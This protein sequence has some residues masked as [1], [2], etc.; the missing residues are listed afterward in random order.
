MSD[1]WPPIRD[2]L[3]LSIILAGTLHSF[4]RTCRQL[5][6][7]SLCVMFFE[8]ILNT[9]DRVFTFVDFLRVNPRLKPL[10]RLIVVSPTDFVASLL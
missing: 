7:R 8:V 5:R 2:F 3:G 6:P 9:W 1:A 4:S 10:V